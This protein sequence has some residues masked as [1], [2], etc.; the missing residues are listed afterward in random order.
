MQIKSNPPLKPESLLVL[1]VI[2]RRDKL[3]NISNRYYAEKN[4]YCKQYCP[5]EAK[6]FE[7][8]C[9]TSSSFTYDY[10]SSEKSYGIKFRMHRLREF[11]IR[12]LRNEG[13]QQREV[14]IFKINLMSYFNR[15]KGEFPFTFYLE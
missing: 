1:Q 4:N 12:I 13:I 15:Q 14:G 9:Y 8:D 6:D 3:S 5:T 11:Y 10:I 2:E 7:K